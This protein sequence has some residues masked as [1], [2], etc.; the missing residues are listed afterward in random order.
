M[1]RNRNLAAEGFK[2]LQDEYRFTIEGAVMG[3][4][5]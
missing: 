4:L 3:L 5:R 1:D 2:L